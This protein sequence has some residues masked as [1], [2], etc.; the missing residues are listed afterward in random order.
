[1]TESVGRA[2]EGARAAHEGILRRESARE[3]ASRTYA[4]ALPF[5]RVRARGLTIEGADGRR[6]L[7][8]LS[9]AGTLAYVRQN[10]LDEHPEILGTR[11]LT[12][13]RFLAA[14]FACIGHVRGQGLMIG[15]ELV[16]PEGTPER[17]EG[18]PRAAHVTGDAGLARRDDRL[19]AAGRP[20]PS[21]DPWPAAP[22]PAAAVQQECLRRGLIV[23][24]GG[25]HASVVRLLP[26]L[27]LTDEQANAV[28]DRLTDAVRTAAQGCCERGGGEPR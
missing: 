22:E 7:D 17:T 11:I 19:D 25:R 20:A 26:P 21:H 15:I 24:L 8:C 12:E 27:T 3:S 16:D 4:R 13:L 28:L 9:G 10:H 2:A 6:Y 23:E 1:M 14:E 5:V 18:I